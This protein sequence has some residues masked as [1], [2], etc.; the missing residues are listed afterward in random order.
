[1]LRVFELIV[2]GQLGDALAQPSNQGNR[3]FALAENEGGVGWR[4][5]C[6]DEFIVVKISDMRFEHPRK[7]RNMTSYAR[8]H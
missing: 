8:K 4:E 3:S 6:V 1:M 7:E 2:I 5:H